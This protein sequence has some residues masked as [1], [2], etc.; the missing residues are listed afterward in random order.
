MLR[1]LRSFWSDFR[2]INKGYAPLL[3]IISEDSVEETNVGL[4]KAKAESEKPA[5]F[6]LWVTAT[7]VLSGER[8][9]RS[10]YDRAVV[11][12]HIEARAG[13]KALIQ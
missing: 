3:R 4:V 6:M 8:V 2:C 11:F 12:L 7:K 13:L 9:Y 1:T 5:D 10:Q